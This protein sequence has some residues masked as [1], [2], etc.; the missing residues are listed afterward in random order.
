MRKYRNHNILPLIIPLLLVFALIVAISYF[1][2]PAQQAKKAVD[3]FYSYEQDAKFSSSWEMLHT[4]MKEKFT[5]NAYMQD[6]AHVFMN[7]FGADSF[8]FSLSTPKRKSSW[9]MSEGSELLHKVYKVTVTKNY[10]GKYGRFQFVQ[11]VYA[12][13]EDKEW[14][15]LWDYNEGAD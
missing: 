6:R 12:T 2:S 3:T 10:Y 9:A 13:K 5:R 8:H 7:H 4:Q 11:D 1:A 14:K 15:I